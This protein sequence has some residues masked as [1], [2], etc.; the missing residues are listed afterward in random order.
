[1]IA[2]IVAYNMGII[3]GFKIYRMNTMAIKDTKPKAVL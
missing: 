2:N 3:I 1:M